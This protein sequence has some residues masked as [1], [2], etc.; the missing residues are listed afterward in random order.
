MNSAAEDSSLPLDEPRL[1]T[2][3]WDSAQQNTTKILSEIL[4][5]P[6]KPEMKVFEKILDTLEW[7][8]FFL[9]Q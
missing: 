6:C 8:S 1:S 5:F 7:G 2:A 9:A 3:G 4:L